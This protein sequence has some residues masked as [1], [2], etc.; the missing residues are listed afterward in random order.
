MRIFSIIR[1]LGT[2]LML[3]AF[4]MIGHS[5]NSTMSAPADSAPSARFI[6]DKGLSVSRT[7][8]GQPSF[9][10]SMKLAWANFTGKEPE[11][12]NGLKGLH[13][14]AAQSRAPAPGSLEA[15]TREIDFWVN[16][17]SKLGFTGP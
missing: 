13:A 4:L 14:R 9:V 3:G 11:P 7:D 16:L 8:T 6:N 10:D 5:Y 15:T 1:I 17:T 2:L 12:T